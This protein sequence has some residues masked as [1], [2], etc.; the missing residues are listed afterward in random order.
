MYADFEENFGLLTH[1]MD[2]YERASKVM[3]PGP[4]QNE[5][6]NMHIAKATQFFGIATAR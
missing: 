2:I 1:S 3:K 4:D 6:I 5:F